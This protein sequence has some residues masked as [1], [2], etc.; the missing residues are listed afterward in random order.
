MLSPRDWMERLRRVTARPEPPPTAARP[1]SLPEVFEIA[2]DVREVLL[3]LEQRGQL[4]RALRMSPHQAVLAAHLAALVTEHGAEA[5]QEALELLGL[6]EATE[7]IPLAPSPQCSP[8]PEL[9]P[10]SEAT[11]PLPPEAAA[12]SAPQPALLQPEVVTQLANLN[13]N[14]WRDTNRTDGWYGL[15]RDGQHQLFLQKSSVSPKL[16]KELAARDVVLH[17]AHGIPAS[18]TATFTI[19]AGKVT[20]RS[21]VALDVD[22]LRS[23]TGSSFE[24][25]H[26]RW[27]GAQ[28]RYPVTVMR[29]EEVKHEPVT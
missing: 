8:A 4:R 10:E 12:L 14:Q 27:D 23:I 6:T 2:P 22:R 29:G 13:V 5:F 19:H 16:F 7:A 15:R 26:A 1:A 24:A 9:A 25:I 11:E 28:R 3:D 17:E 20:F 18:S 21:V